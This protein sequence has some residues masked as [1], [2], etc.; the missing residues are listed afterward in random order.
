MQA[1]LIKQ[2][3]AG[4]RIYFV[5]D[6]VGSHQLSKSYIRTL[7]AAGVEFHPF[8]TTKGWRNRLQLNFRNHRKIVVVDGKV[9]FVGGLN[10]G[11]EYMG[12]DPHFGDWRDTHVKIVGPAVQ[13]VQLA[14][15]EDWFWS[16]ETL[17][18][19]NWSMKF[20]NQGQIDTLILPTGPADIR[21]TCGLFFVQAIHSARNRIWICS[22]YFV[23]DS[24]VITALHLAVLRG[25]D[26]RIILPDKAD[27]LLVYLCSFVALEQLHP[28]AIKVY[29]YQDGF[30]HQKVMLIDNELS[31]VGTANLD[32]RSIR[33]NFEITAIFADVEFAMKMEE[34]L[35]KDFD[36]CVRV[37]TDELN[38]RP[39]WFRLGVRLAQ[40][41]A[42][43]Q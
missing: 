14:F 41:T 33:L 2:A 9:A 15:L 37:E 28:S 16:T 43:I 27:H 4:V 7:Q 10:I 31:A 18:E 12:R 42:P 34:M 5:Y 8:T 26:V 6:E 22:P 35:L 40:L 29:R 24:Q 39:F 13:C 3:N 20:S 11:D 25:V 36:R 17:P 32:N 38:E 30:M 19:L 21:E 23:P 1:L